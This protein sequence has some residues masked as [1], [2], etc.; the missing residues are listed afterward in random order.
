MFPDAGEAGKIS[1]N[2]NRNVLTCFMADKPDELIKIVSLMEFVNNN[3]P[4]FMW[5]K[6]RNMVGYILQIPLI[7]KII[8]QTKK[9]KSMRHTRIQT[10]IFLPNI[11]V[12]EITICIKIKIRI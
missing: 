11:L 5:I 2:L 12:K 7:P 3:L 6:P 1:K 9:H 4:L 8:I 10:I